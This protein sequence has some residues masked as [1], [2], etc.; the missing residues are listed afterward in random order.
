LP[1]KFD[2]VR[3]KARVSAENGGLTVLNGAYA[4][5]LF[6]AFLP[7]NYSQAQFKIASIV[8]LL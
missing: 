8:I 3:L 6:I 2:P 5:Y 7:M 1:V 4:R